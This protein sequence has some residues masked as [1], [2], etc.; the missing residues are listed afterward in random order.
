M[1][2]QPFLLL[3]ILIS[4]LLVSLCLIPL[5]QSPI[6]SY[7]AQ[8][9]L[10]EEM[11]GERLAEWTFSE[12]REMLLKNEIPWEK[13]PKPNQTTLP[14]PLPFQ[15]IDLPGLKPKNI[16]RSFTL[17]CKKNGEKEGL[18]GE[19]YR[20]IYVDIEF[21]PKLSQK[22][23]KGTYSYR[24]A[25]RKIPSQPGEMAIAENQKRD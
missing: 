24:L 25:I 14:F 3:E 13:L 19:T 11:E 6:R 9:R 2:K 12:I 23:G 15:A 7:K 22:K 18:K 17:R 1:K 4:I 21:E 8:V 16:Q 10:L 20:M 5:I